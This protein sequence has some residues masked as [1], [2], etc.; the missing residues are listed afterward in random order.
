[1]AFPSAARLQVPSPE[2]N[3]GAAA[4]RQWLDEARVATPA[5][6]AQG[7]GL[8]DQYMILV[9]TQEEAQYGLFKGQHCLGIYLNLVP[10]DSW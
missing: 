9:F 3:A 6:P 4:V 7:L 1:M 8:K 10:R 5:Q 2:A